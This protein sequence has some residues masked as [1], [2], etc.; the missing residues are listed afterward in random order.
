MV[1]HIR[2]VHHFT[3]IL[4]KHSVVRKRG[5]PP[6]SIVF[7]QI[8]RRNSLRGNGTEADACKQ[9]GRCKQLSFHSNHILSSGKTQS[10]PGHAPARA[11]GFARIVLLYHFYTEKARER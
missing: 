6:R 4:L 5:T 3:G 2:T 9:T 7:F 11:G 1:L 10:V 8:I